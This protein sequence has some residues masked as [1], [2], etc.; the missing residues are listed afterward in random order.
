MHE[1]LQFRLLESLQG[2]LKEI[3]Q[4]C[5]KAYKNLKQIVPR[6]S[7]IEP[8]GLQNQALGP[9]KSSLEPSKTH[10]LKTLNLKST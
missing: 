3:L 4:G 6:P 10:F 9:P 5:P 1:S 7:K 2:F 8:W